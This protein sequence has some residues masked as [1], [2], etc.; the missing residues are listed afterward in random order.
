MKLIYFFK[1]YFQSPFRGNKYLST[2]N[3]K[4]EILELKTATSKLVLQLTSGTIIFSFTIIQY[5]SSKNIHF[6]QLWLLK[7]SWIFLILSIFFGLLF[8]YHLISHLLIFPRAIDKEK[9]NTFTECTNEA[10][11][12]WLSHMASE[13]IQFITFWLGIVFLILFAFFNFK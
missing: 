7:I 10:L 13:F 8:F 3:L 1:C 6:S 5:L 12:A 11:F 4:G 9:H 2:S